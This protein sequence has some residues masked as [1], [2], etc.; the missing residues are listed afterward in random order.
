MVL[1][2]FEVLVVTPRSGD[3]LELSVRFGDENVNFATAPVRSGV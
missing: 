2:L 3:V 1:P